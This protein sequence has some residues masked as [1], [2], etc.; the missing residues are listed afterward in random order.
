MC[1]FASSHECTL[2]LWRNR[3][4]VDCVRRLVYVCMSVCS[5]FMMSWLCTF[6]CA[7]VFVY[8]WKFIRFSENMFVG[9]YSCLW[10]NM[11]SALNSYFLINM[12]PLCTLLTTDFIISLC[13]CL[14]VYAWYAYVCLHLS[15]HI[16]AYMC[17]CKQRTHTHTQTHTHTHESKLVMQ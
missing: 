10:G 15:S 4:H 14:D 11:S 3:L 13:I 8:V 7:C 6:L 12:R 9:L 2:L 1:Y 16:C 17:L 5:V